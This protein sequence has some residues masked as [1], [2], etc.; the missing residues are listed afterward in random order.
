MTTDYRFEDEPEDAWHPLDDLAENI[1]NLC[2]RCA[3]LDQGPRLPEGDDDDNTPAGMV[4]ELVRRVEAKLAQRNLS[5]RD[6][7]RANQILDD[8]EVVRAKIGAN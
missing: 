5:A 2:L 8:V 1:H 7:H 4:D 3:L 6:Q